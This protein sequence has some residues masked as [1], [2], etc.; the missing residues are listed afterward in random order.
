VIHLDNIRALLDTCKGSDFTSLRDIA[1]IRALFNTG[2]RR[3]ELVNLTVDDWD[4]RRDFLT[5]R[6]KT[7]TRVVPIS[8]STG[9]ALARYVRAR[10]S[11]VVLC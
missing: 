8:A 4:R 10:S 5:R 11:R 7:G 1:V 9:E 2:C 3:G 6:D